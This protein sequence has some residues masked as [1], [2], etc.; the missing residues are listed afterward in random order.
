MEILDGKRI[1]SEMKKEIAEEVKQIVAEGKPA[2]YLVA[3]LVGHDG[4]SETYVAHKEKDCHEVGVRSDVLR[5]PDTIT[6]A[7]L[8]N[9]ID[10]INKN[11]E[12]N[13]VIVQLPLPK[14]IA[15]QKV[16]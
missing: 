13:G 7:E 10:K 9:E 14:H 16:I 6:E 8:L 2:P 11:D 12:I 5:F 1:A 3:I 4:A 15:E